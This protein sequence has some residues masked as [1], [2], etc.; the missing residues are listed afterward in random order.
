MEFEKTF[1]NFSVA[2][3]SHKTVGM[4]GKVVYKELTLDKGALSRGCFK[5]I[6]AAVTD[7]NTQLLID[8]KATAFEAYKEILKLLFKKDYGVSLSGITVHIGAVKNVMSSIPLIIAADAQKIEPYLSVNLVIEGAAVN[9]DRSER[10]ASLM[11]LL[12][13]A[14]SKLGLAF[15]HITADPSDQAWKSY[16]REQLINEKSLPYDAARIGIVS[17]DE[18]SGTGTCLFGEAAPKLNPKQLVKCGIGGLGGND[19]AAAFIGKILTTVCSGTASV[20]ELASAVSA[21]YDGVF[22]DKGHLIKIAEPWCGHYTVGSGFFTSMHLT[23]LIGKGWSALDNSAPDEGFAVFMPENRSE[24]TAVF[25]NGS[26]TIKNYS[27]SLSDESFLGRTLSVIESCGPSVGGIFEKTRMRFVTGA[28]VGEEQLKFTVKPC[29]IVT[30]TTLDT[31]FT[32]ELRSLCRS[33]PEKARLKLPYNNRFD[34]RDELILKNAGKPYFTNDVNGMFRLVEDGKSCALVQQSLSGVSEPMTVLGDETWANYTAEVKVLVTD[35]YAGLAVRCTGTLCGLSLR[36]YSSGKCTLLHLGEVI[37]EAQIKGFDK[38]EWHTIKLAAFGEFSSAYV[39]DTLVKNYAE[40]GT[41]CLRGRI[42]LISSYN[43]NSF[44][45]LKVTPALNMNAYAD[46]A[47]ALSESVTYSGK[48]VLKVEDSDKYAILAADDSFTL[49]YLGCGFALC[50][51]ACEAAVEI[52][53]DDKIL[54]CSKELDN[55]CGSLAVYRSREVMFGNHTLTVRVLSGG[56]SL[57]SVLTYT[58]RWSYSR[59]SED[60]LSMPT[61]QKA[62][63]AAA[64]T[65]AAGAAAAIVAHKVKKLKNKKH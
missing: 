29:S 4:T 57:D 36:L 46:R 9:S 28:L 30:V 45:E 31:A 37:A 16:L 44:K 52:T 2:F 13:A 14:H 15:T 32:E 49:N 18:C 48:P 43:S 62:V 64:A 27:V 53:L 8:C 40:H 3:D 22:E 42:A 19:G 7:E 12:K 10:Y 23:R 51:S 11:K 35:G 41:Y 33:I 39:D 1:G 24:L 55:C 26:D 25:V 65:A 6:T 21:A 38:N 63:I 56:L 60:K 54:E 50:A 20:Y 59:H 5:G 61:A 58:N 34:N 47:N 17:A